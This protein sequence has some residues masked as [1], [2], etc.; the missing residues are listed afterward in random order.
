M[1]EFSWPDKRRFQAHSVEEAWPQT[2]EALPV[3]TRIAGE[4]IGRQPF[5]VFLSVGGHPAALGL[6]EVTAMP[7]CGCLEL[8][9][10][11]EQVTGTVIW[12]AD[13]NH[14]V[15]IQ[16]DA[17]AEHPDQWPHFDDAVG[18]TFTGKVAMVT[19]V[20]VWVYLD[21]CIRG[22][23]PVDG[24]PPGIDADSVGLGECREVQVRVVEV[25]LTH[26]R[27]RLALA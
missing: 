14:Q 15:K 19:P 7:S 11:G 3:G 25:D 6:A 8:P 4:V 16:L 20:G 12:R 1:S 22:V 18:R 23:I 13:H 10:L 26:H 21:K 17:W 2:V 5:G 27:V 24:L 9:C